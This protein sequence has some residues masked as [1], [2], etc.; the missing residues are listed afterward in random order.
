ML[1]CPQE[2]HKIPVLD[3]VNPPS[4]AELLHLLT[5]AVDDGLTQKKPFVIAHR[6]GLKNLLELMRWLVDLN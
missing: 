5:V 2:K 4:K 1:F 3:P 6:L